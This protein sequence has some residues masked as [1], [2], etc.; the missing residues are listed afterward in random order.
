MQTDPIWFNKPSILWERPTEIF[1]FRYS[2]LGS[3]EEKIN[4]VARL[5][6]IM[7]AMSLILGRG[8]KLLILG[9]SILL[10][11]VFVYETKKRESFRGD[12]K[13]TNDV[14]QRLDRP[15]FVIPVE[16]GMNLH[17]EIVGDIQQK[18][19]IDTRPNKEYK[20]FKNQLNR[21]KT[22]YGF[23]SQNKTSYGNVFSSPPYSK[24]L[25]SI[26]KMFS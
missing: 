11:S 16:E 8:G 13:G 20:Y 4:S 6:I 21:E 14:V 23:L 19:K 22:Q 5:V 9:V 24:H 10:S 17:S 18:M 25:R 12:L 2:E 3:L 26:N 15:Q 7:M 1:P